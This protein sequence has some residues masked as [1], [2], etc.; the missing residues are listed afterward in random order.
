LDTNLQQVESKYFAH[1]Y[2]WLLLNSSEYDRTALANLGLWIDSNVILASF[3][4]DQDKYDIEQ[5]YKREQTPEE[6]VMEHFGNWS[7]EGGL[8]D[9]RETRVLARRRRN[10]MQFN[11]KVSMVIIHNDSLNHLA[12]LK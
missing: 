12:D 2:N 1:P 7:E 5:I 8:H 11:F 4:N 6:L 3:K 10:L 9:V